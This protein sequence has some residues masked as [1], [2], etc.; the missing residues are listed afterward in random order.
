MRHVLIFGHRSLVNAFRA[1]GWRVTSV[2]YRTEA[3]IVSQTFPIDACKAYAQACREAP[4]DLAL[5][6]DE[7]QLPMWTRVGEL[8]VPTAWYAVDTHIHGKWHQDWQALYDVVLVAQK[9]KLSLYREKRNHGPVYWCPL[10]ADHTRLRPP[11]EPRPA[12]VAFVGNLNRSVNPRRVDFFERLAELVDIRVR[13]GPYEELYA[14]SSMG[15]NQS[16]D[17]EL[18]FRNFEVLASGAALITESN[19]DGIGDCLHEGKHFVTYERDNV[20]DC[21]QTIQ[22]LLDDPGRVEALRYRGYEA[23]LDAHLDIHRVDHIENW[24][25]ST[26]L[27]G[28][29]QARFQTPDA[30][31][32]SNV[33][34][35][36]FASAVY[37]SHGRSR[38]AE[39][40]RV[41]A[42]A[43]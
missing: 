36:E 16:L 28:L 29:V 10:Y 39:A 25:A 33:K 19:T 2:G 24:L 1:R 41:M 35:F 4:V 38:E 9:S 40:Y 43:V 8:P 20:D 11:R 7:S 13:Q 32:H 6:C 5:F 42:E 17:G 30:W 26:D 22:G 31:R 14:M 15:L 27:N 12:E 18:N 3:D 23:V 34:V 37:T 21:A